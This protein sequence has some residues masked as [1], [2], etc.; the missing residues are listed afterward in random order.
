MKLQISVSSPMVMSG[1]YIPEWAKTDLANKSYLKKLLA[2]PYTKKFAT[3]L[4]SRKFPQDL[5]LSKLS[6]TKELFFVKNEG[7]IQYAVEVDTIKTTGLV[8]ISTVSQ[9]SVWRN[10]EYDYTVGLPSWIFFKVLFPT[11][12]TILSDSLQSKEGKDFWTK[13]LLETLQKGEK[14]VYVLGMLN[15]SSS[16]KVKEVIPVT[17]I[18][19]VAPYYSHEPSKDGEFYRILITSI[20]LDTGAVRP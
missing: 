17:D 5:Y 7:L 9:A 2:K 16:F 1:S 18:A 10:I 11:H 13:R 14:S 15:K 8:A 19:D 6:K 20:P 12:A 3:Y 4:S